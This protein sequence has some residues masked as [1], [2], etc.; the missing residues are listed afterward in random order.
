M[1]DFGILYSHYL[2]KYCAAVL[3]EIA[4]V[5]LNTYLLIV[6]VSAEDGHA[7]IFLLLVALFAV[8]V[9]FGAWSEYLKDR[10]SVGSIDAC[11]V[12]GAI[13][14][15]GRA[16]LYVERDEKERRS[17]VLAGNGVEIVEGA[18]EYF[19]ELFR[20]VINAVMLL[21]TLAFLIDFSIVVSYFVSLAC[22]TLVVIW[23]YETLG[24]KAARVERRRICLGRIC[25]QLWD[26]YVLGNPAWQKRW[27]R[28][29]DF[30]RGQY[31]RA[32]M[33]KEVYA[34]LVQSVIF[35]IA[36]VPTFLV[37]VWL[38]L[39]RDTPD[40]LPIVVVIPR[41]LQLLGG[42]SQ[43]GAMFASWGQV[44]GQLSVLRE[45]LV[46]PASRDLLHRVRWTDITVEGNDLPAK[47]TLELII[48]G[49][50][51]QGRYTVLGPNGCGKTSLL[52]EIKRRCAGRA[53][54]VGPQ[55]R[56]EY[57]LA[58]DESSTGER[59]SAVT[60]EALGGID[61]ILLLDEWDANLDGARRERLDASI[62]ERSHD[63]VI[64]EVRHRG[65]L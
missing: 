48:G 16:D 43:I 7:K 13:A 4:A 18:T 36:H 9:S 49:G 21:A 46:I 58:A 6:L 60:E 65:A 51:R 40:I 8:G 53:H 39:M 52:L 27:R 2:W 29:F 57:S 54:Y 5:A 31:G 26:G 11:I 33:S 63:G 28:L 17:F 59:A 34:V 38:M 23:T 44:K 20:V 10:W 32:R 1:D 24:R 42:Q 15:R 30:A 45:S 37:L 55:S 47:D 35:A 3:T 12:K 50:V 14:V 19:A 25:S 61:K 41:I 22:I 56:S 62:E 64:V